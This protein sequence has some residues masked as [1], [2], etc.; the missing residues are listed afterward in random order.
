M[1]I[2]SL[3]IATADLDRSIKFYRDTLG[4]PLVEQAAD[5]AQIQVG[6]SLLTLAA[7]D[8]LL[9]GIYHF[10]FNIPENQ[11][12]AAQHWLS[13]RRPLIPDASGQTVFHSDN[14]NSDQVYFLD[15]DGNILELI[16]R[17]TLP[18]TRSDSPFSAASL[19]CISEIGVATASVDETVAAFKRDYDLDVYIS[20]GEQ[21]A[22]VGDE[23][24]LLITVKEGRLWFPD[25]TQPARF[26]PLTVA[27]VDGRGVGQTLHY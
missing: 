12:D 6:S 10:A 26:L 13:T 24:G 4:L 23:R 19:L 2:T 11:L 25:Q 15:P 22:P 27:I 3:Q 14:W 1:K 5:R 8:T 21:F 17:H 9:P 18:E 7:A 16:A 20:R